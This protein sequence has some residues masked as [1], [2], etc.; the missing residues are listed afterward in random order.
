[1]QR[2]IKH[3]GVVCRSR[4]QD[5]AIERIPAENFDDPEIAR[6]RSSAAVGR[7]QLPG[8]DGREFERDPAASRMRP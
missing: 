8:S 3:A 1:L 4:H 6:L 5:D 2:A 7:R